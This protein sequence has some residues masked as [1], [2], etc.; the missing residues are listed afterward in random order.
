LSVTRKPKVLFIGYGH[1]AKSLISKKLLSIVNI[2]AL[3]SK[4][5]IKNINQ[6]KKISK[7]DNNYNYIFLLTRPNTFLTFGNKFQKYLSKKS[8]VISC[9]AGIKLSTIE[10]IL[11][12]KKIIRIMPNVMATNYKSQTHIY[13]KNK[14]YI[15]SNLKKL[16]LSFG[17]IINVRNEDQV[18][19]ATSIFGSGPA[20][21]AY[22][23][24]IFVKASKK[25]SK[26]YNMNEKEVIKLFKN[27][28]DIN[29][30]SKMLD[31]FVNSISSEKGTTQSGI[32]YIKSQKIEKIIYTTLHKAYKRAKEIDSEKKNRKFK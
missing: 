5:I 9:M 17:T 8:L 10:K 25:L 18:N 30:T 29:D 31:V 23:V 24:N 3:N 1:L 7:F 21:I 28:L 13:T 26:P 20:F 6:R 16:L 32:N 4:G 11:K 12:T 15:D 27:V 14:N 19:F 2:H 22:I